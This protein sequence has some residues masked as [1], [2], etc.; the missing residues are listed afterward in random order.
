[1][2]ITTT[3]TTITVTAGFCALEY[4]HGRLSRTLPAGTH[5]KQRRATYVAV[6]L[7]E[8]LIPVAPQE[9]LTTDSLSVRVTM[10][11]RAKIVDAVAY[12]ETA[13][14]P[15]AT[16]YLAAQVA[17]R[18]MA[19]S[20]SIADIMARNDALDPAAI[21]A[22]A[23]AAGERCGIEVS[24]VLV[25]DIILPSEIRSAAVE[26]TTAKT[27]GQAKLEA[28]RAETAALRALANAG[29]VL[30]ANPALA[31]LRLIQEVPYGAKLVLAVGDPA[32]NAEGGVSDSEG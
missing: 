13:R 18:Q 14:D 3:F 23:S 10:S 20:L 30:E 25:K 31:R 29:R 22:A 8:A 17:L 7:R 11:L 4:R 26:L 19:A 5:F 16:I 1:M 32:T 2:S 12:T 15:W 9:I 28:A 6:D 24:E 27:R 21:F